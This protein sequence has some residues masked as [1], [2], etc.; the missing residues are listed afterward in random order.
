MLGALVQIALA[1]GALAA[2][3]STWP[4]GAIALGLGIVGALGVLTA[5]VCVIWVGIRRFGL[6]WFLTRKTVQLLVFPFFAPTIP[7]CSQSSY[8]FGGLTLAALAALAIP[9][10]KTRYRV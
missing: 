5:S 1:L 8:F 2:W 3:A 7:F 9:A 6:R 10:L 4:A